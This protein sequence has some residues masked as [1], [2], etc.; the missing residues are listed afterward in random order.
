MLAG[1]AVFAQAKRIDERFRV[2]LLIGDG[3]NQNGHQ[4]GCRRLAFQNLASRGGNPWVAAQNGRTIE[5]VRRQLQAQRFRLF[6]RL[7]ASSV[8]PV[9]TSHSIRKSFAAT[10]RGRVE[11]NSSTSIGF[12][13]PFGARL[14]CIRCQR[15]RGGQP[16]RLGRKNSNGIGI[17]APQ[18]F[19]RLVRAILRCCNCRSWKWANRRYRSAAA[20]VFSFFRAASTVLSTVADNSAGGTVS[21]VLFQVLQDVLPGHFDV[22]RG[23]MPTKSS[24]LN[25]ITMQAV[26]RTA[27]FGLLELRFRVAQG[28]QH[29]PRL[30][31]R[32]VDLSGKGTIAHRSESRRFRE[33][34]GAAS[35]LSRADHADERRWREGGRQGCHPPDGPGYRGPESRMST[36]R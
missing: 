10:W 25:G 36:C 21:R 26:K 27:L 5:T 2:A 19:D 8:R 24:G 7:I 17:I 31:H 28:V 34:A 23:H 12:L 13:D 9:R 32:A 15:A 1:R 35:R 33:S 30:T 14:G 3:L 22:G 18:G 6:R 4:V 20:G 16:V 29:R 11:Q